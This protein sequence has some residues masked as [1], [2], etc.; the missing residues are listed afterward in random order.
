MTHL[1]ALFCHPSEP[2]AEP[3]VARVVHA[4]CALHPLP[5]PHPGAVRLGWAGSRG[6]E[7]SVH[8]LKACHVVCTQLQCVRH[9]VCPLPGMAHL[10]QPSPAAFSSPIPSCACMPGV[11]ACMQTA[12]SRTRRLG[13][14]RC[15][16]LCRAMLYMFALLACLQAELF[17][18]HSQSNSVPCRCRCQPW[19][20]LARKATSCCPLWRRTGS[21]T[22]ARP[23]RSCRA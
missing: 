11:P 2:H 14:Q 20:S 16:A 13:G 23:G 21:G 1:P 17:T 10:L 8:S 18:H 7:A 22:P 3:R 15:A 9:P 12:C 6:S 5:D 19:M 4:D